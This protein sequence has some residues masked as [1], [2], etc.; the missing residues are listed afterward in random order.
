MVSQVSPAGPA[1]P[2]TPGEE[3]GGGGGGGGRES[4]G[5]K[6]MISTS[7]HISYW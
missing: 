7:I 5:M 6:T 2:S 4:E 3:D 1:L